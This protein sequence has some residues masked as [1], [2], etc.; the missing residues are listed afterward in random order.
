MAI[1]KR[2]P[3][4]QIPGLRAD[5]HLIPQIGSIYDDEFDAPDGLLNGS[6]GLNPL[7]LNN[8]IAYDVNRTMPHHIWVQLNGQAASNFAIDKVITEASTFSYTAHVKLPTRLSTTGFFLA[9]YDATYQY[10]ARIA[11]RQTTTTGQYI[12]INSMN[13]GTVATASTYNTQA[14]H[15]EFFLQLNYEGSNVWRGW[16]SNN[17]IG[18]NSMPTRT[19]AVTVAYLHLL[20]YNPTTTY[21]NDI[22]M[23]TDFVRR[24]WRVQ[25]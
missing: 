4:L 20:W 24:N 18:W 1:V 5:P 3:R 15:D 22:L 23:A 8:P 7:Y 11:V 17:G 25:S 13:S 19:Q 12:E 2:F 21:W 9:F 14:F 10:M 6:W 16:W